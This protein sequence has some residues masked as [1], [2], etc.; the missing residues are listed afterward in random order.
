VTD[1]HK[2]AQDNTKN[3]SIDLHNHLFETLEWLG[4]RDLKGEE[5]KEEIQRADAM[6]RVAGQI[7]N[8]NNMLLNAHKAAAAAGVKMKLPLLPAE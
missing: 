1:K 2:T 5:L 6:C 8:H 3:K 4:D 7:I